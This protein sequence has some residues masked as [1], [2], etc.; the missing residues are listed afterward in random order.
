M[1][2]VSEKERKRVS[3]RGPDTDAAEDRAKPRNR[4]NLAEG[5]GQTQT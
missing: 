5:R 1:E 2:K 3:E 4:R